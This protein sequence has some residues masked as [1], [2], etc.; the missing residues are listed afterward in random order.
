[1]RD[2]EL[3]KGM[4]E[5][6]GMELIKKGKKSGKWREVEKEGL[7]K[8]GGDRMWVGVMDSMFGKGFNGE[9]LG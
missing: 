3:K 1:M 5:K 7:E 4:R 9:C 6:K 8:L 2:D